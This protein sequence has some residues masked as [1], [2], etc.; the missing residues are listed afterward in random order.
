MSVQNIPWM[1][2]DNIIPQHTSRHFSKI[3]K[4]YRDI[5]TTDSES[6]SV[7]ADK[8]KNLD[9]I[10]A[11]DV[12]CGAGRYDLLLYKYLKDKLR[13]TCLDASAEMLQSLTAYLTRHDI[14]SFTA[15]Q[16]AAETMPFRDSE[17]DCVCTFNAVHHFSL[18]HF[19]NESSRV[20]KKAVISLYIP[21]SVNK[22]RETSGGSISPV[23][24]KKKTACIPWIS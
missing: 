10:N 15:K 12:G 24:M 20:I 19:L 18:Q 21:D 4:K 13:L 8:L 11:A 16:S 14:D 22:M 2:A 7:I 17:L 6:I 5:R 23:L 3:A 9:T 1:N